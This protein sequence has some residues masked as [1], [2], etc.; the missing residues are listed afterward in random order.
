[1]MP[2]TDGPTGNVLIVGAG[3]TG[4]LLAGDLAAA[5]V[6]C[7]VLESRAEETTGLTR[8]FAVHARTL[9]LLDARG[10]ADELVATGTRAGRLRLLGS[11]DLD[12]S[13]L[14]GRFPYVLVTPQYETERVL[15]ERAVA[16]GAEIV[17]GAE[18]VG[19]RQDAAGVDV[20][21]RIAGGGARTFRAS[22]RAPSA[23]RSRSWPPSGRAGT[24]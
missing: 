7:T 21:A 2:P 22:P 23:T 19:L 9:E 3:P 1:M 15:K 16:A 5:G 14:P 24:G 13:R 11:I 18:A 12:M 17:H 20:D 4:L 10:V 6:G 8:A